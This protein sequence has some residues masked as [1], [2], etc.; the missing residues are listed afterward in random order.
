MKRIVSMNAKILDNS[1]VLLFKEIQVLKAAL[2][3][4][5]ACG[6][7]SQNSLGGIKNQI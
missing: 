2:L 5:P 6:K 4:E 3:E 1:L 7:C